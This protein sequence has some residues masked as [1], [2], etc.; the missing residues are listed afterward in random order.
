MVRFRLDELLE[1]KADEFPTQAELS[2]R[3][4]ISTVTINAI[5]LNK[6]RRIDLDTI[7]ALAS[8]LGCEPGELFS[9]KPDKPKRGR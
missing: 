6:T 9:Y 4:R 1:E 8:A 7:N 5:T 2:R 3:S